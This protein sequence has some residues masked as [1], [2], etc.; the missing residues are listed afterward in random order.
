MTNQYLVKTRNYAGRKTLGLV[1][2][3]KDSVWKFSLSKYIMALILLQGWNLSWY[4]VVFNSM[5]TKA[6]EKREMLTYKIN[7][8]KKFYRILVII[9]SNL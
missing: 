6:L 3:D 4:N 7:E 1:Y 2:L 5:I 8:G 9:A